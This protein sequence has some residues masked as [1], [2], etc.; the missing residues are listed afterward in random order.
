MK[1]RIEDSILILVAEMIY[2]KLHESKEEVAVIP[3]VIK[4][5]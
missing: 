3:V 1:Y 2:E 4:F 5:L